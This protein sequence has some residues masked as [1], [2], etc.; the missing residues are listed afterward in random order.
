MREPSSLRQLLM[1]W[2]SAPLIA[3]IG[4][5]LGASYFIALYVANDA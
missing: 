3:L 4:V 5:S 2:L 1:R